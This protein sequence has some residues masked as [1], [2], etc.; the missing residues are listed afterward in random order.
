MKKYKILS[1]HNY[2]Q[3]PGGED[4][5]VLNEKELL[6]SCGHTVLCYSRRNAEISAAGPLKKILLGLSSFF[7]LR[8]Y[9][10]IRNLIEKEGIEIVHVHNTVP[11][12]SPSVFCAALHS[13]VPVVQ[14]VHNFRLLCPNGMLYRE[15]KV[16]EECLENGLMCSVRHRC[17]RGSFVQTVILALTIWFYRKVGLYRR[18]YLIALTRLNREKLLSINKK[19]VY[20]TPDHVFVKPNFT[21]DTKTAIFPLEGR[22]RQMIY[23]GRLEEA[24]GVK[25]LFKTW[26]KF[27]AKG[28]GWELLVCGTG[29]L[30]AWCR[31]YI[32]SRKL[33][34]IQMMGGVEHGRLMDLIGHSRALI[35]PTYL[36]EGFGMVVVESMSCGTP[37]IGSGFGNVGDIIEEGINGWR[38]EK[39]SE[40]DLL[41]KLDC[42]DRMDLTASTYEDYKAHYSAERNY[43]ML[44]EIY[45]RILKK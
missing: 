25:L 32:E 42:V 17:Y 9:R 5:V 2:Y 45:D 11:L 8:T 16:C 31:N 36:Y 39:N 26:A 4:T 44:L 34:T 18:I 24:K 7:S 21:A 38:F 22:K 10:E 37:I 43:E 20:I 30:E 6:E 15:G 27:E 1:V 14:T 35:M 19:R 40:D 23:A 28:E 12:I 13:R 29:P 33:R 3:L 41:D